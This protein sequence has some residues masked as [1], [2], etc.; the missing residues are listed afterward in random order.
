MMQGQL[1][2][3]VVVA[4]LAAPWKLWNAIFAV[5]GDGVDPG[6]FLGGLMTLGEE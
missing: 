1:T 4:V 5:I 2:E 6:G 3:V